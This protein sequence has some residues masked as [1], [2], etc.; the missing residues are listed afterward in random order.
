M[1]ASAHNVCQKVLNNLR[2]SNLNFMISETPY[3][4][5]I[6]LRKRFLK[7]VSGP[8]SSFDIGG[9]DSDHKRGLANENSMLRKEIE[10]IE[11]KIESDREIVKILE[12]KV[13]K[14]EAAAF[15]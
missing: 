10:D 1:A 13:A 8:E 9:N 6:L 4:A 11:E 3:S 7:E 12:E 14:A 15:K 2:L 5:Q